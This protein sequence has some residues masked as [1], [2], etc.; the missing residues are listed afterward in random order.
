[1]AH[2]AFEPVTG[3]TGPTAE[4]GVSVLERWRRRGHGGRLFDHAVTHARNR[5]AHNLLIHIARENSAMLA[6]VRRA[7]AEVQF[8]G[9]EAT[10]QLPL[11]QDT[12]ATQ[13]EELV[14]HQAAELDYRFK[15][16]V[17][18]LDKLREVCLLSPLV[19]P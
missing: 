8:D 11:P 17:L 15:R 14:G 10:A 16:H 3:E 6:I 13:I 7:G 12:L 19:R 2:L 1:M 4:F 9:A 18:R 5:G